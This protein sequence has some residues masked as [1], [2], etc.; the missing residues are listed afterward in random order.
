MS[1]P[2]CES[3]TSGLFD[4][5]EVPCMWSNAK[6]KKRVRSSALQ[7]VAPITEFLY[8]IQRGNLSMSTTNIRVDIYYNNTSRLLP[9]V[10]QVNLG[11]LNSNMEERSFRL[12]F[13]VICGVHTEKFRRGYNLHVCFITIL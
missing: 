7:H 11:F 1:Y 9:T 5:F 2:H 3:F 8:V 6:T 10:R 4:L 12:Y 13:P